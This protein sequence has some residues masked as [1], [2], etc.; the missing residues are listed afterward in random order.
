M[1]IIIV[2]RNKQVRVLAVNMDSFKKTYV[3]IAKIKFDTPKP[4]SFDAQS[5]PVD[6]TIF[7]T[8]YQ[9]HIPIGTANIKFATIGLSFHQSQTN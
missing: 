8:A 9:K 2:A 4:I 3:N 7:F 6:S 5:S 1:P